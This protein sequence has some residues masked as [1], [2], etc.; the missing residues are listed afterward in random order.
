MLKKIVKCLEYYFVDILGYYIH[1]RKFKRILKSRHYIH[2]SPVFTL[3]W[4]YA[5]VSASKGNILKVKLQTFEKNGIC[6]ILCNIKKT[7]IRTIIIQSIWLTIKITAFYCENRR[8]GLQIWQKTHFVKN[9]FIKMENKSI[10]L[11]ILS[12]YAAPQEYQHLLVTP[13]CY[14]KYIRKL[15]VSF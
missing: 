13:T 1:I 6:Q 10:V 7:L 5:R 12:C 9:I 2:S 14:C 3:F 11:P 15:Q 8:K 4:M